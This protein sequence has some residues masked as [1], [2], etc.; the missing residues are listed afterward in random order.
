MKTTLLVALVAIAVCIS[1]SAQAQHPN[2]YWVWSDTFDTYANGNLGDVSNEQWGGG[3]EFQVI[4]GGCPQNPTRCVEMTGATTSRSPT[5]P[6]LMSWEPKGGALY[7]H[8]RIMSPRG[9]SGGA[10][11]TFTIS[12]RDEEYKDSVCWRADERTVWPSGADGTVQGPTTSLVAAR[13]YELDVTF[14]TVT[15]DA[16][17]YVDG[18]QKYTCNF[19]DLSDKWAIPTKGT[20]WIMLNNNGLHSTFKLQIDD[21]K[22]G[23]KYGRSIPEM[24]MPTAGCSTSWSGPYVFSPFDCIVDSPTIHWVVDPHVGYEVKVFDYSA[25]PDA[26]DWYQ[27]IKQPNVT[28]QHYTADYINILQEGVTYWVYV[29]VKI[30]GVWQPWS[31]S[32][33]DFSYSRIRDDRPLGPTITSHADGGWARPLRPPT[34][35]WTIPPSIPHNESQVRIG[36]TPGGND[37]TS[38]GGNDYWQTDFFIEDNDTLDMNMISPRPRD[39]VEGQVY[40]VQVRG[41]NGCNGEDAD[42]S[43]TPWSDGNGYW[44]SNTFRFK[45]TNKP[46]VME[47]SPAGGVTVNSTTPTITW[48]ADIGVVAAVTQAQVRVNTEADATPT[49]GANIL[50]D[51]TFAVSGDP[52]YHQVTTPLPT[53]T[54]LWAFVR[55]YNSTGWGSWSPNTDSANWPAPQDNGGFYINIPQP[56]TGPVTAFVATKG[57]GQNTLSWHNPSDAGFTGVTIRFATTGYPT[58]P[59]DGALVIDKPNTPGSDDGYVH[60]GLT[61]GTTY[62]YCVFAHNA[63]PDYSTPA[64]AG[65]TPAPP[66][67][68]PP[69]AVT[70]FTATAGNQQIALSWRNPADADF[71]GTMIRYKTNGYPTGV[72]DGALVADR[73]AAPYSTDSYTHTSLTNGTTYYYAAFAHDAVPNYS[74]MAVYQAMPV[75][76][77]TTPPGPVIGFAAAGGVQQV[78]LSWQNPAESD[79]I[80]TLIRYKTTGYPTSPTDGTLIADKS[81]LPN[82]SDSYTHTGLVNGTTYYY[83]AWAHDTPGNNSTKADAN[84]TPGGASGAT[85]NVKKVSAAITIDGTTDDWSL[86]DFTT[87]ARGGE[88]VAGDKAIVGFDGG[89]LYYGGRW[90]DAAL[91]L[92]AADH[93]ATIYSRHD[94]AYLYLLVRCDDSDVR[95]ANPVGS[96]WANDCIEVYID[97]SHN[98]GASPISGSTS[99]AQL[100]L[101][102]NGQKNVYMTTSGYAT[103]VTNGVTCAAVRDG[104]GWWLEARIQKSALDP[105]M[106]NTGSF[107]VDFV[108]R[109]NDNPDPTYYMGNPADSTIYSWRDSSSGSSFPSKIPDRWGDAALADITPPGPVTSFLAGAGEQQITL[110][111]HNPADVDFSGTMIRY[112]TTGYPTSATDGFLV[113][114]KAGARN[115]NDAVVHSGL[116]NGTTYYYAAF[117]HDGS[118]NYSSAA[119]AIGTPVDMTAP[120]PVSAFAV[121]VG[122]ERN[123]LSWTNPPDADLAGVKIMAKTTGYPTGPS[124]GTVVFNAMGTTRVHESLA[125]GTAYYYRAYAYDGVPNYSS[126]AQATGIPTRYDPFDA[127]MEANSTQA[128]ITVG[129]V[130]SAWTGG[131]YIQCPDGSGAIGGIRVDMAAH[132]LSA[133]QSAGAKGTVGTDPLT[134]E[135]RMTASWAKSNTSVYTASPVAISGSTLGGSDLSYNPA[136]GAGQKGLAGASG[137][138]NIGLAVTVFG[139]VTQRQTSDPKYFYVDDGSGLRDGTLTGGTENVGVRVI[140]DPAS[141]AEGSYVVVTGVSSCFKDGGALKRQIAPVAGG[142]ESLGL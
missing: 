25:N 21:I 61:N 134:D 22:L 81:G 109:D 8:C 26:D 89:T 75:P 40:Y 110:T 127:K 125:N 1:S 130:T 135:K 51:S 115:A 86:S 44:S 99:D 113:V 28:K 111:W 4:S 140:A 80:G 23:S 71:T 62:Y 87:K 142:I 56:G 106:P 101:D 2:A 18:V 90:T 94:S 66:D 128:T 27:N 7:F 129:V 49:I 20:K 83:S 88:A 132:G 45:A 112:K 52:G 16:T 107:G 24:T 95:Y 48:P 116:V 41:R 10:G 76:P 53:G 68:T 117:A 30:N 29:R 93:T 37:Y 136:T 43:T 126:Y 100:V 105:D 54:H 63:T 119:T 33:M 104:A 34:L 137:P 59:T 133:G 64:Y 77:D 19:R 50:Y 9:Q 85:I 58:G 5:H 108:F 138:N 97:P 91:P 13:W 78:A 39:M 122:N 6:I 139:R 118:P 14:D 141:W 36:T 121:V 32:G 120:W 82:A 114:D 38:I 12:L 102:A 70:S 79:F 3:V 47:L 65:A 69:G 73:A 60:T 84:A 72:T 31:A 96:N 57:N 98:H 17:W 35:K 15:K 92:S 131:F 42:E 74:S 123:N 46:V 103:Q 124:D 67:T 11:T 55:L